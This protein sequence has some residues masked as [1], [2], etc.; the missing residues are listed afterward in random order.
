VAATL[1]ERSSPTGW[2][3]VPSPNPAGATRTTLS[4]V[5]CPS[6]TVC[7]AAGSSSAKGTTKTLIE[8]WNG[9]TWSIVSSPGDAHFIT[10]LT[11]IAC[12]STTNCFVVGQRQAETLETLIE[13]WNG[14]KWS[15]VPSPS[16]TPSPQFTTAGINNL[17]SVACASATSCFAVGDDLGYLDDFSE[18]LVLRWNGAKWSIVKS[19][20]GAPDGKY[21]TL[22]GVSCPSATSCYAVGNS[23][24][25]PGETS[26]LHSLIEHWNGTA[27]TRVTSADPVSATR[28]SLAGVSCPT[29][30]SCLAVGES[31]AGTGHISTLVR[32]LTG[33]TWS[34]VTS[35]NPVGAINASLYAVSCRGASTCFAVGYSAQFASPST[36]VESYS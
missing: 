15:I 6:P 20:N 19:P 33:T 29:V 9:K 25:K 13:R 7:F 35:P 3:V 26:R 32:S 17:Q 12:T 34:V 31:S 11:S 27:W 4:G 14:A 23:F 28:S 2:S 10:T 18:T 21:S 16:R 30:T 1:V 36:L 8:R 22:S 5:S 24:A